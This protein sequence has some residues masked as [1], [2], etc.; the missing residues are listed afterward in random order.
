MKDF[1]I[2][3]DDFFGSDFHSWSSTQMYRVI[4]NDPTLIIQKDTHPKERTN[5]KKLTFG[6]N[7]GKGAFSTGQDLGVAEAEALIFIN[8]F[9]DGFP[10]L[11][12]NLELRKKQACERG[13]I[14]LSPYT[15][16]RYFFPEFEEMKI[17]EKKAQSFYSE[18]YNEKS[19]K[20]NYA[21]KGKIT[22]AKRQ[23]LLNEKQ[24]MKEE[25]YAMHPE[26]PVLWK[27]FMTL[28]GKLERRALNFG[29][30]G[31]CAE[32]TKIALCLM[33]L[34]DLYITLIV[35]DEF[36]GEGPDKDTEEMS[37][38]IKTSMLDAGKRYSKEMPFSGDAAIGDYWIH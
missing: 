22:P 17:I 18:E 24:E 13:W 12:E 21:L 35:H 36:V 2:I 38:Q 29:I 26:L 5:S 4:R 28:K 20:L 3:G 31:G 14:E 11:R 37:Q 25:L 8:G 1:F 34:L 23:E 6:I 9:L 16:K 33:H 19:K 7:Y 30:Q 10:G 32:M 27:R 15:K